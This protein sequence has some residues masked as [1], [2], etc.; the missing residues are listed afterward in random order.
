MQDWKLV[1]VLAAVLASATGGAR[2][3]ADHGAPALSLH[4]ARGYADI[5]LVRVAL[6]D[7]RIADAKRLVA[8]AVD[9]FDKA[10]GDASVMAKAEASR[11]ISAKAYEGGPD[12]RWVPISGEPGLVEDLNADPAKA[13]AVAEADGKLAVGDRAGA[14]AALERGK[15]RGEVVIALLPLDET[16]SALRRAATLVDG[17]KF[18]EA[19][20]LLLHVLGTTR[21]ASLDADAFTSPATSR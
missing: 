8:E 5:E 3:A 2:G 11:E 7:G 17:G 6:F 4:G 14:L 13:A 12:I 15:A 10:K 19:H 1:M 9:S 16:L 20:A 21:L 18:Y